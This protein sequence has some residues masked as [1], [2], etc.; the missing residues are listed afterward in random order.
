[1]YKVLTNTKLREYENKR[2]GQLLLSKGGRG[3]LQGQSRKELV[4]TEF[5]KQFKRSFTTAVTTRDGR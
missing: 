5:E 3:R 4:I 2:K 1:M